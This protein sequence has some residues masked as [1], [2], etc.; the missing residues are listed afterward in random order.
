[1]ID[2]NIRETGKG[3][4]QEEVVQLFQWHH[5]KVAHFHTV[6]MRRANGSI[7]YITPAAA[8]GKGWPDLVCVKNRIV[9]I[10]LKRRGAKLGEEQELWRDRIEM[11]GGEWYCFWPKDWQKIV[12][13]AASLQAPEKK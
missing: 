10:E 12:L 13:L 1:M 9:Y 2:P 7:A 6:A 3:G 5:W 4:F 8:D 11:A